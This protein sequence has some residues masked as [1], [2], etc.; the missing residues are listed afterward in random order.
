M[1]R[2][3]IL[4]PQN[5]DKVIPPDNEKM[6]KIPVPR[7]K[8]RVIPPDNAKMPIG[9]KILVPRNKDKWIPPDND[10]RL[11]KLRQ[12]MDK[13]NAREMR[14][15]ERQRKKQEDAQMRPACSSQGPS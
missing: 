8:D 12:L 15:K 5:K 7:N 14:R 6:P 4:V 11:L 13:K 9:A 10:H 2:P 3:N 1:P